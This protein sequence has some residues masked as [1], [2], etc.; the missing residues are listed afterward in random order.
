MGL[1]K[2]SITASIA[3]DGQNVQRTVLAASAAS[4]VPS[5]ATWWA[6]NRCETAADTEKWMNV[7]SARIFAAA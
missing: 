3:S 5:P 2:A 4:A 6:A 7:T 1:P